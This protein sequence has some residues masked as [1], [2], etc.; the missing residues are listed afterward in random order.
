MKKSLTIFMS[1]VLL[2]LFLSSFSFESGS[3]SIIKTPHLNSVFAY[4][5]P[6]ICSECGDGIMGD[7]K[8]YP[9]AVEKHCLQFGQS[10]LEQGDDNCFVI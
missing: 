4:D 6:Y 3:N 1:F 8:C 5:L 2:V 7:N 10:C 9:K